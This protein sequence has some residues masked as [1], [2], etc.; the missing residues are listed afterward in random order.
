L[1]LNPSAAEVLVIAHHPRWLSRLDHAT[2]R[3]A[4]DSV[5]GA[6]AVEDCLRDWREGREPPE[7]DA[8]TVATLQELLGSAPAR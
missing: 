3:S 4:A 6:Q 8:G 5:D 7:L 1:L 2:E